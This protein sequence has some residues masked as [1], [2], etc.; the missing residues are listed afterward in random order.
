V[1]DTSPPPDGDFKKAS[2]NLDQGLKSC[3]AVISGYRALLAG[4]QASNEPGVE[5][6]NISDEP[7]PEAGQ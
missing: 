4:D 6:K 2:S 7:E 1:P 5:N 3:R